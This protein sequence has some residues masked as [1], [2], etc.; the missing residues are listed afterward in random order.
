MV[1]NNIEKK[2]WV[3]MSLSQIDK[4]RKIKNGVE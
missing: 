2:K 3:K 1:K 4:L